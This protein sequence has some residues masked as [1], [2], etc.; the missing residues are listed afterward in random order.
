MEVTTHVSKPVSVMYSDSRRDNK[1]G[2]SSV[3][4]L[5]QASN[6][7]FARNVIYTVEVILATFR[8]RIII[9]PKTKFPHGSMARQH[10]IIV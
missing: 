3:G 8:V 10:S 2:S 9:L 5:I 1:H 7:R 6:L 4:D